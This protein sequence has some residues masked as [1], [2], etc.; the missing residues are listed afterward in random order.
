MKRILLICF[1]IFGVSSA[2]GQVSISA[3]EKMTRQ[4]NAIMSDYTDTMVT[5]TN[6][7]DAVII[8]SMKAL[9]TEKVARMWWLISAAAVGKHLNDNPSLSLNE[10]WFSDINDMK[11]RPARVSVLPASVAKTVQSKMYNDAMEPKEAMDLIQK[12]LVKRTQKIE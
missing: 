12:S 10:I 3:A 7:P 6:K 8:V 11:A 9:Q 1:V 2:I 5:P 4:I